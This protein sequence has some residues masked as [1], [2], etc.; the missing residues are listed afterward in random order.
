MKSGKKIFLSLVHAP[1][2]MASIRA[3]CNGDLRSLIRHIA[4]QGLQSGEFGGLIYGM[5][6]VSATERF[7]AKRKG[8]IL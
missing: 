8:K 4:R 3:L 2:R 6:H 1:D 5:A 7:M